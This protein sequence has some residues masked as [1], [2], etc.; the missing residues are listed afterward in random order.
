MVGK[1][2]QK[3]W[4]RILR[5]LHLFSGLTPKQRILVSTQTQF[6]SNGRRK[7]ASPAAPAAPTQWRP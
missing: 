7:L 1:T 3:S 2:L 5:C 6:E 4:Q